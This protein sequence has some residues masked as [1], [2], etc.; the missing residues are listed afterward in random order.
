MDFYNISLSL[1]ENP[2]FGLGIWQRLALCAL[3]VPTLWAILSICAYRTAQFFCRRSNDPK[4][5]AIEQAGI[6]FIAA[7]VICCLTVTLLLPSL[8]IG[9]DWLPAII[10]WIHRIG[11]ALLGDFLLIAL[12]LQVSAFVKQRICTDI[13][14]VRRTYKYW[15]FVT[16][17]MPAPAAI[18]LLFTGFNRVFT[19]PGYS[20]RS[21]WLC[22]L[23]SIL[24]VMMSDGI[25]GYTPAVRDLWTSSEAA[26]DSAT[27]FSKSRNSKR[28]ILLFI[29]SLSFPFVAAL[30]IFRVGGNWNPALP[31]LHLLHA[32]SMAGGWPQLLPGL[33]L[34]AVLFLSVAAAN[35]FGRPK[36]INGS[37]GPSVNVS[38]SKTHK[39]QHAL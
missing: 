24:A 3:V 17:T 1:E 39:A 27:F 13:R 22:A 11:I 12:Y 25:F 6:Y 34:F 21:L 31:I 7:T 30:P 36:A 15:H 10:K 18:M 35:R 9:K 14:S 29:H 2:D 37:G 20:I 26:P 19:V 32:D 33:I 4:R 38:D 16:Q 5:D 28:G 8:G 23:I